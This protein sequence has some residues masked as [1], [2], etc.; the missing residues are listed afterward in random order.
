MNSK[1]IFEKIMNFIGKKNYQLD[2]AVPCACIFFYAI[3]Y[4]T[5]LIRGYISSLFNRNIA[6]R[7]FWEE[8]PR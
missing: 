8:K 2:D 5:M 7:F 3:Q 6:R 4:V 1:K